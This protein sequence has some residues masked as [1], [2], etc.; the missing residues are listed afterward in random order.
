MNFSRVKQETMIHDTDIHGSVKGLR[1]FHK[2]RQYLYVAH[3]KANKS[4]LYNDDNYDW[5]AIL[6]IDK[7]DP[8]DE[9]SA[10]EKLPKVFYQ[11]L[12]K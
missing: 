10:Q 11:L 12:L 7:Y 4:I 5:K 8:I 2:D 9:S 3:E 1:F 6:T